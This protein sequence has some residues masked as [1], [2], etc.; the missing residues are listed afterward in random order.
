MADSNEA[1]IKQ[2]YVVFSMSK[3]LAG[4]AEMINLLLKEKK[5]IGIQFNYLI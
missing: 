1:D 3:E 4:K 5:E 2:H